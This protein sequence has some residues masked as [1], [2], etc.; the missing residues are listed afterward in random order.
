MNKAFAHYFRL[1]GFR[2]RLEQILRGASF[3]SIGEVLGLAP[4]P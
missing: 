1:D 2:G 3:A 4:I